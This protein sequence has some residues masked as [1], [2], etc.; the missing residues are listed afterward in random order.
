VYS[1]SPIFVAV[2]QA[3]RKRSCGIGEGAAE[4]YEDGFNA[5]LII[6]CFDY[7]ETEPKFQEIPAVYRRLSLMG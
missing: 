5:V 7:L 1:V 3:L 4:I 2:G 6:I